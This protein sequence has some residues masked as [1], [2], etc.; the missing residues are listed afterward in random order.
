MVFTV[1]ALGGRDAVEGL[2]GGALNPAVLA[3]INAL[4]IR[5]EGDIVSR[6]GSHIGDTLTFQPVNRAGQPV[7]LA[8][9]DAHVNVESLFTTLSSDA[10]YAAGVR[11]APQEIGL[12]TAVANAAGPIAAEVFDELGGLGVVHNKPEPP[13]LPGVAGYDP[14]GRFFN[15]DADANGAVD[16]RV[17]F[18]GTVPGATDLLV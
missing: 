14:T 2:N 6:I 16:L 18:V 5:T 4:N 1:D 7:E 12:L 13:R 9:R 8:V 10:L 15:V 3:D 11:G 17:F